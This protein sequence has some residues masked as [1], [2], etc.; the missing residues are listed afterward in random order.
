MEWAVLHSTVPGKR[1]AASWAMD[2]LNATYRP[3]REVLVA[4]WVS[5]VVLPV[6]APAWITKCSPVAKASAAAICSSVGL[7]T[8]SFVDL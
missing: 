8:L 4:S 6:P 2:R 1:P 3:R 5:V 7:S